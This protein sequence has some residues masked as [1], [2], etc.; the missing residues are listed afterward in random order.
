VY[1]ALGL[2]GVIAVISVL[3]GVLLAAVMFWV[4]SR[5]ARHH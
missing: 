2:T 4:R 1:E 3:L 5:E